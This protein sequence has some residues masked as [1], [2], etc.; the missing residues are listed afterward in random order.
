MREE[1]DGQ[2]SIPDLRRI[3]VTS[4]EEAYDY[5]DKGLMKR[6]TSSTS[7][8]NKSSR[9][10]SIFQIYMEKE[11]MDGTII[12]SKIR[13]VDLAGSEKYTIRRDLP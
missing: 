8:N 5:L 3:P 1:K 2:F 12:R 10:H 4:I 13:I 7:L 6:A 11:T 9:S